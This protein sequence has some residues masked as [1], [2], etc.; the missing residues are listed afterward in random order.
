MTS[1]F[2]YYKQEAIILRKKGFTYG[3]IKKYLGIPIPKSTL[4]L[5]FKRITLSNIACNRLNNARSLKQKESHMRALEANKKK[6]INYLEEIEKR[7]K[8]LEKYLDNNDIAKIVLAMLYLGEGAK[9]PRRSFML[10]NSNPKVVKLYLNLLRKCY[11]IDEKKFRCTLQCRADQNIPKLENF[12]HKVTGI[13]KTQF[14]KARID[15]RTI[16]KKSKKPE[17]KGVC[18]IDYFSADMYNEVEKIIE[19]ICKTGL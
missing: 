17:Y 2:I 9:G 6:R 12:W 16:G 15:P 5:W 13:P 10:G 1:T 4:S 3:E 18:R 8:H 14:Y 7:T 19:L 11:I